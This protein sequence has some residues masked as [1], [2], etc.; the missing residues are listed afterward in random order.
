ME[1]TH[2]AL[3][4]GDI[5]WRLLAV[6]LLVLANAFFVAAE[7]AL[8]SVRQS[9]IEALAAR[10]SRSARL[11][12]DTLGRINYYISAAQL[13]IT[14]ASLGLGWIGE[15]TLASLVD[16]ALQA[17]RVAAPSAAVHFIAA[18]ATAYFVIT[19]L[20]VVLGEQGPKTSSLASAERL[21]ARS[22]RPLRWFAAA[23]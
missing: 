21:A 4:A 20:H 2:E 17:A 6:L 18:I 7:F 13:G 23:T 10:G 1:T 14:M 22:A 8:V 15:A 3:T 12:K 19:Y 5:A 11:V 9:R 16:R